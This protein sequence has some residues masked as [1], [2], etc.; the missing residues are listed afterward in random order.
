MEEFAVIFYVRLPSF[1]DMK[2]MMYTRDNTALSS[3]VDGLAH[4]LPLSYWFSE[5]QQSDW[6]WRDDLTGI[7][8]SV[9]VLSNKHIRS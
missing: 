6:H 5:V 2:E 7:S 3:R 4:F 1:P 9:I 8:D